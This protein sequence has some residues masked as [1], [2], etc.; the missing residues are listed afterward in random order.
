MEGEREGQRRVVCNASGR[1]LSLPQR[2]FELP[3]ALDHL[4]RQVSSAHRSRLRENP[5]HLSPEQLTSSITHLDDVDVDNSISTTAGPLPATLKVAELNAERGRF[6]CEFVM[7]VRRTPELSAIDVWLLNELDL[8]MGRSEQLHTARLLAY[9]LG[10]NYAWGVEFIELTNG[11]KGEQQRVG[12]A[13]ANREGLHGNAILSRW[14]LRDVSIVRMPGMGPLYTSNGRET[15]YGFEKRLGSRMTLFATTGGGEGGAPVSSVSSASSDSSASSV[16]SVS[17]D[18]GGRLL[19]AATHAQ[20][21]WKRVR[22]HTSAASRSV[23]AHIDRLSADLSGGD[24]RAGHVSPPVPVPVL[25][26]GDTWS[27]TC[28]WLGMD[29]I[30]ASPSPTNR[31]A[32]GKVKLWGMGNDDYI[33]GRGVSLVGKPTRFPTVGRPLDAQRPEFVLSDHV[34]VT[35]TVNL[36][37][38]SAT[39]F[40]R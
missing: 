12:A 31:V 16:S 28:V 14:P 32:N 21:S 36:S 40:K 33:C 3:P 35:A 15:A 6:W 8:G 34:F 13:D 4:R 24:G 10:M 20:T 19:L 9:G 26:G 7:Q 17:S 30:V 1:A 5:M 18:R 29:G 2:A 11:N 38:T 22:V 25:L 27:S 23:K 37:R 39:A